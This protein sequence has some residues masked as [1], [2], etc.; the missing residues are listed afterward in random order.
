MTN[1]Y[2]FTLPRHFETAVRT[3][4][5]PSE[6]QLLLAKKSLDTGATVLFTG[7]FTQEDGT[8][9]PRIRV[10]IDY[11]VDLMDGRMLIS[12]MVKSH[13]GPVRCFFDLA[14][15]FSVESG[16]ML[17]PTI[18]HI[19][20]M[21]RELKKQERG[22]PKELFTPGTRCIVKVCFAEAKE[23]TVQHLI[24]NGPDSFCIETGIPHESP[25]MKDMTYSYNI[26]HVVEVLEHKS[27]K[28]I[29]AERG[30]E[31]QQHSDAPGFPG[32]TGRYHG[33][34]KPDMIL[35]AMG[36]RTPPSGTILDLEKLVELVAARGVFRAENMDTWC[37]AVSANKTKLK[38]AVSQLYN[39]ALMSAAV[40]QEQ[41]D[42]AMNKMMAEDSW[43]GY[44]D[45][46]EGHPDSTRG[47]R[48]DQQDTCDDYN[49][50]DYSEY[51][52]E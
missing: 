45:D 1:F 43:G 30:V 34:S 52:Y 51:D 44:R 27:G 47:D 6:T 50:F 9:V 32:G 29:I 28:L 24:Q 23:V 35:Q 19:Q 33:W 8:E 41:E 13:D 31:R 4:K 22:F 49:H 2:S 48:R 11:T 3:A 12:A 37:S 40:A 15:L 7:R 20:Q 10:V 14:E 42:D 17:R 5:L 39:R 26:S 38:R 16:A 36:G 18:K 46:D 21:R 25:Y